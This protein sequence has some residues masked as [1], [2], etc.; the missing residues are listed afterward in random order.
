MTFQLGTI[1]GNVFDRI[2]DRGKPVAKFGADLSNN[3]TR[4]AFALEKIPQ[5]KTQ[6]KRRF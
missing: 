1:C 5:T 3:P 6:T 2:G 4:N